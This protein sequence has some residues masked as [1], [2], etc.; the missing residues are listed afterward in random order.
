MMMPKVIC[1]NCHVQQPID[2]VLTS[3]SNQ[4]VI[5]QCQQC[6]YAVRNIQTSKG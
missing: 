6:G 1:P 4:N 5:F 2:Q 3:Q